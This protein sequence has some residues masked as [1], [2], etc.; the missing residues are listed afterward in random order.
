MFTFGAAGIR[1]VVVP[2]VLES[3]DFV[4]DLVLELVEDFEEPELLEAPEE[5][6]PLE[7]ALA[8]NTWLV[9]TVLC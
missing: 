9:I 2:F 7:R 6:P 4:E 3:D 1:F 5:R 8:S